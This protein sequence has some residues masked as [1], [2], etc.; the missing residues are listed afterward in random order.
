MKKSPS[1]GSMIEYNFRVE[2]VLESGK[3]NTFFE[4]E[5][6]AWWF[7]EILSLVGIS[8][9]VYGKTTKLRKF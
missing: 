7:S 1:R 2:A 4:T 9:T 3:D 6:Q 8:S 5:D